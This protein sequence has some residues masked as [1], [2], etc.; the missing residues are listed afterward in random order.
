MYI[1]IKKIFILFLLVQTFGCATQQNIDPMEGLNRS[2]YGFNE[3]VDNSVMRPVAKGYKNVM[4]DIAEKGVNNFFNNLKDFITVINDLLQFKIQHAAN[5]AGRVLI[6]T[7]VGILGTIDV[8]SMSGGERR[9]EDFGQTLAFY[10]W[11]N[12]AYL[13]VP[14]LGPS[15]IRDFSGLMVDTLF[16]DPI[17]YVDHVRTRNSM[18]ILQFVDARAELLNASDILDQAALDP[19]AFQRDSYLQY[20]EKLINDG[21]SNEV[22]YKSSAENDF[23]LFEEVIENNEKITD[24]NI[25]VFVG[26]LEEKISQ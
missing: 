15:S 22:D 2:I 8:H 7:T 6:N 1:I 4:P 3:V 23:E 24:K 25:D 9:K 17:T 12:S 10:G 21:N 20:R 26:K 18:R 13:V 19:Y 11:E 14:F 16:I 5:D